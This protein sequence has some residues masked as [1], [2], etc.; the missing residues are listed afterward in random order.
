MKNSIL[1]CRFDVTRYLHIPVNF[2]PIL[3][4]SPV[5]R[6][7]T[8]ARTVVNYLK[9]A[10][11]SV[12]F[13][14]PRQV[15]PVTNSPMLKAAGNSELLTFTDSD[16]ASCE[17]TR[18]SRSGTC[19]FLCNSLIYWKSGRKITSQEVPQKL[20]FGPFLR[21]SHNYNSYKMLSIFSTKLTKESSIAKIFQFPVIIQV[22][23][24][25]SDQSNPSYE[26]STLKLLFSG[27]NE[28]LPKKE[29]RFTLWI[30]KSSCWYLYQKSCAA[31]VWKI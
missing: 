27:F 22:Q 25:L 15:G 7:W 5:R 6:H 31:F 23:E 11:D 3:F 2:F 21:E 10:Q 9:T 1:I 30:L 19:I 8:L 16:F 24:T 20:S 12:L 18:K 4:S 29:S 14:S 26:Q 13:L 28:K 17:E